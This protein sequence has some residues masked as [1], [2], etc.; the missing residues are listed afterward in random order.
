MLFGIFPIGDLLMNTQTR[1]RH[2]R[3][4]KTGLIL[5][6]VLFLA[7]LLFLD[8]TPGNPL[9]T[10]MA[11]V[12]LL[13]ATWWVTD[14]VPLYAT[15]L[16]PMVL[17]PLLGILN[18]KT[19][20]PLY[21]NSTIFL[22]L[23]GFLI[24]L[25]MEQWN[26]HRRI[27]LVII[28]TV[29]GGPSR[30]ILGFMIAAAFLSMWISNT[31]TAI[32]MLPIGMAI[33]HQMD[34]R[35]SRRESHG[36]TLALM[37]G[38]AYACSLGGMATLVGTPPNLAFARIYEISFPEADPIAFGT[39]FVM[40]LPIAAVMLAVV[41]FL[42]TRVL[43]KVPGH[44]KVERSVVDQEYAE[45]GAPR[46]EEK[47]VMAV[48]SLT[49]LLW[50]FRN[51][52]HLGS[53]SIPGWSQLLP[54]PG[55]IDDGTVAIFMALLLFIIPT[56]STDA[57]STTLLSGEG[58]RKLPWGIVLLFGG[59]FALAEGFQTSGLA[60]LIGGRFGA[61]GELPPLLM[62]GL[63]CLTLTFLTEV[64]SNT[65]TTQM[66]LPI[67]ASLS[68]EMQVS[69]LLLMVPATL[70]ASCAF[71][72]PIATPPNAIV[73]GSG[74][75]RIAEMARIGVLI[76]FVGVIL[77]ASLFYLLGPAVFGFDLG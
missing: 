71:M 58:I 65:A 67:L 45:M 60:A 52:L 3:M 64:T 2:S 59:G 62:V 46:P 23:G 69:P 16:L 31:A 48:F 24:A 40:G 55:M 42:L 76:N 5:G 38:I 33:V 28:R 32:M 7:V 63:I 51:P 20:A 66:I 1:P 15:S 74:R 49:A 77:I 41:W 9:P 75:I 50:V 14:A 43:I 53:V 8:F 17:F 34:E 29:G 70:S 56:R 6:P 44:L 36:F 30:L 37:L 4:Q 47:A 13:M 22:F 35:F 72:M 11:A 54:Y 10:R 68:T 61:L 39:W 18:G 12:A 19:T 27:A 25:A 73:F 21:I 57:A 26:L